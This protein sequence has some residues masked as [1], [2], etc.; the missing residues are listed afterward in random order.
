MGLFK[1]I[2]NCVSSSNDSIE[3]EITEMKIEIKQIEEKVNSL[4]QSKH[5]TFTELKRL[6]DKIN[7]HFQLVSTKIDNVLLILSHKSN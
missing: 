7:N 6:E 3:N 1:N 4:F 2:F 5:S